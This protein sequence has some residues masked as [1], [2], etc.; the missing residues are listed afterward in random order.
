VVPLNPGTGA[1]YRGDEEIRAALARGENVVEVSEQVAR[2][3]QLGME[4]NARGIY[5]VEQ[6]ERAP[7]VR[8]AQQP[9]KRV[10]TKFHR[11]RW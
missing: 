6:V 9:S 11:P 8:R 4:L 10:R 7:Q 3:V 1:V 5:A 2:A